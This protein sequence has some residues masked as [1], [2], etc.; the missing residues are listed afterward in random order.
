[1]KLAIGL[2]TFAFA[3]SAQAKVFSCTGTE[4]FWNAQIDMAK[5]TVRLASPGVKNSTVKAKV[6]QAAGTS[7][8][9]AFVAQSKFVNI[10]VV[11]DKSCNDG[12]SD[13]QYTHAAIISGYGSTPMYGCCSEK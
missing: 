7:E 9:F 12:M 2:L 13:N 5:N 6:T 3:I 11:T 8:N 1:M 10:S 4:P